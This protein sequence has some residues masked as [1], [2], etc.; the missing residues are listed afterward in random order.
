LEPKRAITFPF[1][2]ARNLVKFQPTPPLDKVLEIGRD[3]DAMAGHLKS[4]AK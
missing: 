3:I 1:L 2:S 4:D